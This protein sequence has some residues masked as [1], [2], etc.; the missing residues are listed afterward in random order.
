[1]KIQQ[2]ILANL[3]GR[4]WGFVAVY[5]FVPLYLQF[6]GIDGYGL[7]GF[8]ATLLG[9]L[10]F[11]DLGFTATL[12][13]EMARLSAGADAVVAMRN[14]LRTFEIVYGAMSILL[15]VLIW[16]LAPEISGHWL[17][18][19]VLT[20]GEMTATIR[21][22]G[23]AIAFQLPAGLFIG[24]M[25]G[26]QK[27]VRANALQ[28]G[29]S[30]FQGAGAVLVLRFLSNTIVAFAGWQLLSN[31]LYCFLARHNLWRELAHDA[32]RNRAIF[33]A[34]VFR[35]TWRYAAGMVG[36]S[37][38]GILL[39]QI[40]KVVISKILNLEML[41]YYTLAITVASIPIT[42]ANVI[43]SAVF[44]RLTGHVARLD[45]EALAI[46][47]QKAFA[48]VSVVVIPIGLTLAAFAGDFVFAWTG[49][50]D[51]AQQVG[52]VATFLVLGQL[53]QALTVV[54]YYLGLA[55]GN[56][57]LNLQIGIT[58]IVVVTPVL[59]FL[60][61]KYGILGAGISWLV[62]NT[63]TLPINMY[64]LHRRFLPEGLR[65]SMLGL[66][67]SFLVALP[68]VLLSRWLLPHTTSRLLIFTE[69]ALASTVAA[70]AAVLAVP[71]FR[72]IAKGEALRVLAVT[73]PKMG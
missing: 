25:M 57:R 19:A 61:T 49:S 70:S 60:I 27:Q 47:Y 33:K 32:L 6:L 55:N 34:Q 24:G 29:W 69:L 72:V 20:P 13:R 1:M 45:R 67:I 71:G 26:L 73:R 28:V 18:S 12:N 14:L 40:D 50:V 63:C 9:V 42:L 37:V 16:F 36:I 66:G 3:I 22:M 64:F 59:V 56:I 21:V 23:I 44:P 41:G 58:S 38:I 62:M 5:L 51:V 8:Y 31:L 4:A 52:P 48:L 30:L 43:G 35:E 46:V 54:P 68:C 10:A 65:H 15:A 53:Q 39:A 2:N 7:V 11:A 17:R